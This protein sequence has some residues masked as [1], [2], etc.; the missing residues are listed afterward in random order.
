MAQYALLVGVG[1]FE[2]DLPV[3]DYVEEDVGDF[4]EV[5][6]T[7]MDVPYENIVSLLNQEATAGRIQTEINTICTKAT[8]GDRVILYF[9]THGKTYSGTSFLA[10]F[11]ASTENTDNTG[12]VWTSNLIT[13]LHNAKCNILA[14]LDSC[15]S[16]QFSRSQNP[17][18]GL[19]QLT[20][21]GDFPGQ[22]KAVFGAAGENEEAY[23][24]ISFSHGCWTYYL[25]EALSGRAPRSFENGSKRITA[26]SL[27][28][29]LFESV[30]NRQNKL[31]RK[32]TPYLDAV[33]PHD[34]L[35]VEH[36]DEEG[37]RLKIK[38]IY[39]GAIDTDSEKQNVPNSE[40][41]IKNFYD[42]NSICEKLDT[43][44]SIQVIIGNK[45][46]GKTF[47]GEYLKSSNKRMIYQSVGTIQHSDIQNLTSAQGD[48][49]GKYIQAWTYSLYT[50]LACFIVMGNKPGR[51]EFYSLLKAIYGE[52]IDVILSTFETS[53][54]ILLQKKL[55]RGVPLG[56]YFAYFEDDNGITHIDGL[57]SLYSMLFGRYYTS[58]KLYFLLDGLDDQLRGKITE[59]QKKILLDLLASVDQSNQALSGVRIVLLFRN[60]LLH[61]LSGEANTNKIISARSCTLSWLSTNSNYSETPLYQFLEKR[62]ITS[63][64]ATGITPAPRLSDILPPKMRE[65]DT[66][67]WILKLTTYTPRDIVS[68]FNCCKEFAG[69]QTYLTADNL[70]SAIRPYSNYLWDEFQDVLSGTVL[71]GRGDQLLNFFN[72]LVQ[73]HNLKSNTRFNYSDF[74]NVYQ[75]NSELADIPIVDILKILYEVG[76]MCV[77]TNSGTYWYFREDPLE[78]DFD[79]W[80][81]SKFEIHTGLWKKLH[82]W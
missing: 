70:W 26:N 68:F 55:K 5:L 59:E 32:Q 16:T 18:A 9:S 48:M 72:R 82:I 35:V 41:M 80:K 19:T 50:Y 46:T 45:G 73:G 23:S 7:Y 61:S 22:Y 69:E 64:E 63:A 38:D 71:S 20:S 44:S 62:I 58:E 81:E 37:D 24:D 17:I 39:F 47:L 76:I 40:F 54:R 67:S 8:D 74:N 4:S 10:A 66:W 43:N 2:K 52:A 60:D 21:V 29:Y 27:Q 78:F 15:H 11:D 3:V 42:L 75:E 31:G 51:D 1:H 28:K 25:I 53:K 33:Y 30:S 57:I 49:R 77:H 79:T 13:Q 12:W 56:D 34:I 14:F 6:M 36:P 65:D